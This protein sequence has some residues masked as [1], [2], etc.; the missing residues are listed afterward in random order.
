MPSRGP[1]AVLPFMGPLSWRT[2]SC[3][4]GAEEMEG[5][6][7][8]KK[9]QICVILSPLPPA[10]VN[11]QNRVVPNHNTFFEVYWFCKLWAILVRCLHICSS[12]RSLMQVTNRSYCAEGFTCV[13]FTLRRG[14]G[15]RSR[16]NVSP[17][18]RTSG[19]TGPIRKRPVDGFPVSWCLNMKV[20]VTYSIV[21]ISSVQDW[22]SVSFRYSFSSGFPPYCCLVGIQI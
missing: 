12:K 13:S 6:I 2:E 8:K 1:V 7:K 16:L 20:Y 21:L 11:H 3:E 4:C 10:P 14:W 15:S 9:H 18:K 5:T 22:L 17:R 19:K